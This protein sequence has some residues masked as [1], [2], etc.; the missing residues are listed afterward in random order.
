MTQTDQLQGLVRTFGHEIF[1]Y[2][3]NLD[4][5]DVDAVAT[6]TDALPEAR[7]PVLASMV[8]AL[9][10]L[11]VRASLADIPVELLVPDL[12]AVNHNGE[13]LSFFNACRTQCGGELPDF[14]TGDPVGDALAPSLAYIYPT[15]LIFRHLAGSPWSFSSTP[16][17]PADGEYLR[18]V[19]QAILEDPELSRLFPERND[20]RL[21]TSNS[22]VSNTGRA[23]GMQLATLPDAIFNSAYAIFR[24]RSHTSA[25]HLRSAVTAALTMLRAAASG[26]TVEVPAWIGIGN[27]AL[28]EKEVVLPWGHLRQYPEFPPL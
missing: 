19:S 12:I 6:N 18:S 1:A 16:R 27:I 5:F 9:S 3:L 13:R 21:S 17:Y 28:P 4:S 15:T 10:G 24:F 8:S 7:M 23:G 26:A 11:K 14:H 22:F 2:C 25:T 20:E